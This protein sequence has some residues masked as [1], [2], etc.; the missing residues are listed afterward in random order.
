MGELINACWLREADARPTF[1]SI[2]AQIEG[3][4]VRLS[5]MEMAWLDAPYGHPVY[6]ASK[7]SAKGM[8]KGEGSGEAKGGSSIQA[9]WMLTRQLRLLAVE[10]LLLF[11]WILLWPFYATRAFLRHITPRL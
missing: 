7:G 5:T 8:A 4:A 9:A 2:H 10:G 3:L 6:R 1:A 11:S